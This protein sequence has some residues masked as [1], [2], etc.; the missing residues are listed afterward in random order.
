MIQQDRMQFANNNDADNIDGFGNNILFQTM[1]FNEYDDNSD[2]P[3]C[4]KIA[5]IESMRGIEYNTYI[6]PY[7]PTLKMFAEVHS[8]SYI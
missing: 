6:H 5:I 7:F 4:K 2:I 1:E 3:N 8:S